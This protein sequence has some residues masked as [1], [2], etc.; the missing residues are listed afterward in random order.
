[1]AYMDIKP[2]SANG[3]TIMLF[4]GKNF[5]GYYWSDV[6]KGL[7]SKGFRVIV[8]DQIGF[9]RSSKSFIH[10]SFHLLARF[11]K[12][13]LDTLGIQKASI[14]GAFNG[15]NVSHTFRVDVP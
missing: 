8:P 12:Q 1:M 5:A 11:N 9:G 4:H 14:L 7:A 10:Y 15:R 2:G 3:K 13:L 6:I